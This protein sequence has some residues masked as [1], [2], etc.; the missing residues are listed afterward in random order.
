[1]YPTFGL[2]NEGEHVTLM[3]PSECPL[4]T[5]IVSEWTKQAK[6]KV[7]R[8]I[9]R[10]DTVDFDTDLMMDALEHTDFIDEYKDE[11]NVEDLVD[12]VQRIDRQPKYTIFIC[13]TDDSNDTRNAY[14]ILTQLFQS[15]YIVELSQ[16]NM[17]LNEIQDKIDRS[18]I[19]ICLLSHAY[20]SCDEKLQELITVKSKEKPI[21]PVLVEEMPYPPEG[22]I[23]SFY[24][25][26]NKVVDF[27]VDLFNTDVA[28]DDVVAKV[29]KRCSNLKPVH[30]V[31]NVSSFLTFYR[32]RGGPNRAST[33]TDHYLPNFLDDDT[34]EF[35]YPVNHVRTTACSVM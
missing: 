33:R 11:Y 18:D 8:T 19:I 12:E 7:N 32:S 9:S 23:M 6:Y 20:I 25:D 17:T 26:F 21:I 16:W 34:G 28:V 22:N 10:Q 14:S 29:S 13:H 30:D 24:P 5:N 2:R 1:M 35:V 27:R 15:G 3:P 4:Q 31:E